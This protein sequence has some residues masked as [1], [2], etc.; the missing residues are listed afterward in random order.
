MELR[1]L[2]IQFIETNGFSP[3]GNVQHIKSLPFFSIAFP[4]QGNYRITIGEETA[5]IQE[6]EC[7]LAPSNITQKINHLPNKEGKQ[8]YRWLFFDAVINDQYFLD[9]LYDF[10]LHLDRPTSNYI[11]RKI[12]EIVS[13]PQ[14]TV[15]G[16]VKKNIAVLDIISYL[17]PLG[18]E[19]DENA[20]LLTPALRYIKSHYSE[21]IDLNNLAKQCGLCR[22]SFFKKFKE[23]TNT[24]PFRLILNFRLQNSIEMLRKEIPIPDIAETCGFSDRFHYSKTFKK[25]Y[26]I[27]PIQYKKLSPDQK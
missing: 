13:S 15:I 16:L 18:K 20:R 21:K 5:L 26:G 23:Y 6:L 24:N 25:I 1:N 10:P 14:N 17:L 2:K 7:F 19:K 11:I 8:S 9:D 12:E 4:Y 3:H 27:T 22:T